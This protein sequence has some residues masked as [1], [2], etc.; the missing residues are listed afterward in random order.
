[1]NQM[2]RVHENTVST[3]TSKFDLRVE[4]DVKEGGK[5][6][7]TYDQRFQASRTE[8]SAQFDHRMSQRGIFPTKFHERK[9]RRV[10]SGLQQSLQDTTDINVWE[11]L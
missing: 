2:N 5:K 9:D 4:T 7:C 6:N 11:F 1:M 10:G 3:V 8:I